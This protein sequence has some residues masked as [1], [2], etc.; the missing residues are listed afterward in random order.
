VV[1]LAAVVA[2]VLLGG[3]FVMLRDTRA[4]APDLQVERAT[5][6]AV[7][8]TVPT[9]VVWPRPQPGLWRYMPDAPLLPRVGHASGRRPCRAR[10]CG[11][12]GARGYAAI[13]DGRGWRRADPPPLPASPQVDGLWVGDG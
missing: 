12:P 1:A 7:V 6:D 4:P 13:D 10:R 3:A 9:E 8:S 5:D 2:A 11:V